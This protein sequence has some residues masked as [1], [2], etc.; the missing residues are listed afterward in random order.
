MN[1]YTVPAASEYQIIFSSIILLE[2]SSDFIFI[3]QNKKNSL[4]MSSTF[5]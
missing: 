3:Y 4:N 2:F 1:Q 5:I